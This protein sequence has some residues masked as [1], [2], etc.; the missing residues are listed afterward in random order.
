MNDMAY[1]YRI[2]SLVLVAAMIL[3]VACVGPIIVTVEV[4]VTLTPPPSETAEETSTLEPG[5]STPSLEPSVTSTITLSPTAST[6]PSVTPTQAQGL[7][8]ELL[9]NPELRGGYSSACFQDGPG[10]TLCVMGGWKL[11]YNPNPDTHPCR[12][13]QTIDCNTEDVLGQGHKPEAKPVDFDEQEFTF[14]IDDDGQQW[15]SFQRVTDVALWQTVVV[16]AGARCELKSKTLDYQVDGD[17]HQGQSDPP[18]LS[19]HASNWGLGVSF[20]GSLPW[21][22]GNALE[23]DTWQEW[24]RVTEHTVEFLADGPLVTVFVRNKRGYPITHQ[25]SIIYAADLRCTGGV[26]ATPIPTP[27]PIVPPDATPLPEP[28]PVAECPAVQA[29]A[30][31]PTDYETLYPNLL[32]QECPGGP[33]IGELGYPRLVTSSREYPHHGTVWLEITGECVGVGPCSGWVKWWEGEQVTLCRAEMCRS[34]ALGSNVQR[35][36]QGYPDAPALLTTEDMDLTTSAAANPRTAWVVFTHWRLEDDFYR[37]GGLFRDPYDMALEWARVTDYFVTHLRSRGADF[38]KIC[39]AGYNETNFNTD[40]QGTAEFKAARFVAFEVWRMKLME[41]RGL[42]AC[43]GKFAV[44]T[45]DYSL[46]PVLEPMFRHAYLQ[47][48]PFLSHQYAGGGPSLWRGEQQNAAYAAGT[49]DPFDLRWADEAHLIDRHHSYPYDLINLVDETGA[50]YVGHSTDV[51]A[52]YGGIERGAWDWVPIWR[53]SWEPEAVQFLREQAQSREYP[54]ATRAFI[55]S[56]AQ[57]DTLT[58]EQLYF[59]YLLYI[60]LLYR[61]DGVYGMIFVHGNFGGWGSF[62]ITGDMGRLWYDYIASYYQ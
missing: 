11:A 22:A 48:H 28:T 13:G 41:E 8:P 32:V 45:P 1:N 34:P 24:D 15:F 50:D 5:T 51:V 2:G 46:Y 49:V 31:R 20:D 7:G 3:M 25:E 59:A 39:F 21:M 12:S 60:D 57:N 23:L 14:A 55:A 52:Y 35:Y 58:D 40:E 29:N 47:G 16:Q 19:G 6:T 9:L 62:E 27:T 36:T 10:G 56:Q 54:P 44:G 17:W 42:L 38:S 61:R 4:P 30:T 33:V 37:S 26:V 53:A 43:V 18:D